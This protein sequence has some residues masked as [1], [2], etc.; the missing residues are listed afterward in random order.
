MTGKEYSLH[1]ISLNGVNAFLLYKAEEAILVDSGRKGSHEKILEE[2]K[3]LGLQKE[4]LKLLIL[5][6][7]HYDHAGSARRLK[8]ITGCHVMIHQSEAVRLE[9]GRTSIPSGTRWKARVV[10]TVGRIFAR[11]L[12]KFP[13]L[14]P[15]ILVEDELQLENFGFS[16]KVIHCPGHTPGSM[17][18]LLENKEMITGDNMFGLP[19]KRVF[20]PFAENKSDLMDSWKKISGIEADT[21][22]PAH[23]LAI[24][25]EKFLNEFA[26][27]S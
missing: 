18:V 25:R 19:G 4:T 16:G 5:T 13:S 15:D 1:R 23:G 7:S 27:I 12:M 8:E 11:S 6:H 10:V 3:R 2:M 26:Q 17:V 14:Q 21:Y 20:P 24:S 9:A 22:H